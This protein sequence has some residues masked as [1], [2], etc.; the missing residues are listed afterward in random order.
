MLD[1]LK[2]L[3]R[4]KVW[5]FGGIYLA[6]GWIMLQVAVV[7]KSTLSLPTWVDQTALVMLT[8]TSGNVFARVSLSWG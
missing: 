6:L 8:T 5:L 7:I 4:R 1:F 3:T 2:E